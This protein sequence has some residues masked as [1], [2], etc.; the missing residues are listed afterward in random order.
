M[1]RY[2]MNDRERHFDRDTRFAVTPKFADDLG[3]LFGPQEPIPADVD[4]AVA[5]AARRHLA[6][7]ARRLWWLKWTVPATAAAAI[8]LACAWWIG[9]GAGRH[10]QQ[11]SLAQVAVA[12]EDIDQ[13]GKVNILDA[14]QLARHIEAQR[15]TEKLWDLNGD[16]LVDRRDVDTV[17][18]AAVRLSKGV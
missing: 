8:V 3:E 12:A 17:A 13:N 9:P 2:T 7:P 5:E 6:K 4:R 18:L 15:P 10:S 1:W 14:F 16:G 11:A